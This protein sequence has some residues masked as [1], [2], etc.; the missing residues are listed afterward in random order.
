MAAD[1][2]DDASDDDKAKG[3]IEATRR[4]DAFRFF[5]EKYRRLPDQFLEFPRSDSRALGANA[6]GG[7]ATTIVTSQYVNPRLYP[8]NYFNG[9]AAEFIGGSNDGAIALITDFVG[10]TGTFTVET[11]AHA[12]VAGDVFRLIEKVPENVKRATC[13]IAIWLIAGGADAENDTDPDV[14]QHSI[15]NF[16]ETFVDG[17]GSQVR[18]PRK[19]YALLQKFISRIGE[20]A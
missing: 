14:K 4:I 7:S 15:G 16:S 11:L 20:M 8:D 2:W 10:S 12:V 13:E 19:A 5:R 1:A 3:L 17:A 18:L 6:S 9:W